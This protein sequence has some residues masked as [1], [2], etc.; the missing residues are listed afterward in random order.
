MVGFDR[1]FEIVNFNLVV[2][3]LFGGGASRCREGVFF[4]KFLGGM[5][6][7]HPLLLL[8]ISVHIIDHF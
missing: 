2:N 5:V 1:S 3:K 6:W 8:P 7:I 4:V